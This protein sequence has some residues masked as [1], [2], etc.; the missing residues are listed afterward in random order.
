MCARGLF[1][2]QKYDGL[3]CE[4]DVFSHVGFGSDVSR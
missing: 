4:D 1:E 3:K 2:G